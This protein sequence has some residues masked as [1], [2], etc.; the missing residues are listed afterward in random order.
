MPVIDRPDHTARRIV[1]PYI[2]LLLLGLVIIGF[3]FRSCWYDKREV[4]Y[5]ISNIELADQTRNSIDVVFEVT[6]NTN[7]QKEEAILI[8]VYTDRGEEIASRITS[9]ELAPRSQKRYRKMVEKWSRPL[10]SDETLSHATVELYK[11]QIF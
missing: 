2:K 4:Y 5:Q 6:N 7:M 9:I 11:P 10:Y 8:R 1:P 3:Y